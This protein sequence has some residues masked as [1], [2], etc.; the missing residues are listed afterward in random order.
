MLAQ[1]G[2]DPRRHERADGGPVDRRGADRHV[3]TVRD[4]EPQGGRAERAD[5]CDEVFGVRRD[6]ERPLG[7]RAAAAARLPRDNAM[8]PRK[9]RDQPLVRRGRRRE[10]QGE[11]DE[12]PVAAHLVVDAGAVGALELGH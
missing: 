11:H 1:G 2:D 7:A 3:D 9:V 6:V 8:V 5:Q 10:A 12:R 4:R